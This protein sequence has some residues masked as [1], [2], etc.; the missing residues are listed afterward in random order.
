MI[1]LS[2]GFVR[3]ALFSLTFPTKI[4]S[5][6]MFCISLAKFAVNINEGLMNQFLPSRELRLGDPLS[7][8][9]F[10]LCVEYLS[11]KLSGS[12]Q[13]KGTKLGGNG[14]T[15]SHLFFI[16]DLLFIGK[17]SPSNAAYWDELL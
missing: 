12:S 10:I 1:A 15:L 16:D 3:E 5:I 14:P 9:L 8:Y 17:A 11:L 13:W 2:G 4:I 6:S 7:P